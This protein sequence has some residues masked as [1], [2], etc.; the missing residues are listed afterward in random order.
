MLK[1]DKLYKGGANPNIELHSPDELWNIQVLDIIEIEYPLKVE[2]DNGTLSLAIAYGDGYKVKIRCYREG[3]KK[4]DVVPI[5]LSFDD[6]LFKYVNSKND[7][8]I[9]NHMLPPSRRAPVYRPPQPKQVYNQPNNVNNSSNQDENNTS[10]E[11]IMPPQQQNNFRDGVRNLG[12]NQNLA[13]SAE[14]MLKQKSMQFGGGEYN[15]EDINIDKKIVYDMFYGAKELVR[16]AD[17]LRGLGRVSNHDITKLQLSISPRDIPDYLPSAQTF[18]EKNSGSIRIDQL[19]FYMYIYFVS[20]FPDIRPSFRHFFGYYSNL[21]KTI[22]KEYGT[23]ENIYDLKD[24]VLELK[25]NMP[26]LSFV[27]FRTGKDILKTN[28]RYFPT[29]DEERKTINMMYSDANKPYCKTTDGKNFSCVASENNIYNYEYEFGPFTDIYD[30]SLPNKDI[31]LQDSFRTHIID[32]LKQGVPICII[33]YGP[34]GSGKTSTL[35]RLELPG[36]TPQIEPGVILELAKEFIGTYSTCKLDIYEISNTKQAPLHKQFVLNNVD[37]SN[38]LKDWRTAFGH[39]YR[40]PYKSIT[41]MLKEYTDIGSIILEFMKDRETAATLNNPDSSRSHAFF[42]V[43]FSNP[44]IKNDKNANI[45]DATLIL[46]D[47]AGVE[48]VF[49]CEKDFVLNAMIENERYSKERKNY[50][51]ALDKFN[52]AV[53]NEGNQKLPTNIIREYNNTIKTLQD[54]RNAMIENE[55]Y[56]MFA[57]DRIF[58]SNPTSNLTVLNSE[59]R[60]DIRNH[61]N[62]TRNNLEKKLNLKLN[63]PDADPDDNTAIKINKRDTDNIFEMLRE[64]KFPENTDTPENIRKKLIDNLKEFGST[65]FNYEVVQVDIFTTAY[66]KIIEKY[67]EYTN[68]FL[69]RTGTFLTKRI[70]IE[71]DIDLM[72]NSVSI[73]QSNAISK[74]MRIMKTPEDETILNIDDIIETLSNKN[75]YRTNQEYGYKDIHLDKKAYDD[76]EVS[77]KI[78]NSI[79]EA[80]NLLKTNYGIEQIRG[81]YFTILM[82]ESFPTFYLTK[83]KH[84]SDIYYIKTATNENTIGFTEWYNDVTEIIKEAAKNNKNVANTTTGLANK[85]NSKIQEDHNKTIPNV[86]NYAYYLFKD[87]Y[88]TMYPSGFV[89]RNAPERPLIADFMKADCDKRGQ[90]GAYINSTIAELRIFISDLVTR[91]KNTTPGFSDDCLPI[92]CNPEISNCF[93]INQYPFSFRNRGETD[94]VGAIAKIFETYLKENGKKIEDLKISIFTVINLDPKANNPPPVPFIDIS[95]IIYFS[96]FLSSFLKLNP[97]TNKTKKTNNPLDIQDLSYLKESVMLFDKA[98][99]DLENNE[100][101]TGKQIVYVEKDGNY[102][103]EKTDKPLVSESKDIIGVINECKPLLTRLKRALGI[104]VERKETTEEKSDEEEGEEKP[105]QPAIETPTSV[106]PHVIS[107]LYS[108]INNIIGLIEKTNATTVIGALQFTDSI[109]KFGLY[110]GICNTDTINTITDIAKPNNN[111]ESGM[112]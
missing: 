87:K 65:N 30:V 73:V 22:I 70:S 14:N 19:F 105:A 59:E 103:V 53:N 72:A 12:L 97:K 104:Q 21:L 56:N 26:I 44:I 79:T 10:Y 112:M 25:N 3:V 38:G 27:K 39:G 78:K 41:G 55:L 94:F 106:E 69:D 98:L 17:V 49:D 28:V 110:K 35:V 29:I 48:N 32:N 100:L 51:D 6:F 91:T 1:K 101:L 18:V 109:S 89:N 42:C 80:L 102:V 60:D 62:S 71:N 84:S 45:K 107:G 58:L 34:S 76:I 77:Q 2:D 11:Y 99:N 63:T 75:I 7:I 81:S 90:E 88:K 86:V 50:H 31:I 67:G 82:F 85:L 66:A 83:L 13:N 5:E 37:V 64:K 108:Y 52:A 15:Y 16:K 46:C 8:P 9:P 36:P 40:H 43:K 20:S 96:E 54:W 33:G 24:K 68:G 74:V 57:N 93:G 47:F 4:E 23:V 95:Y 92:Q 111:E 61:I